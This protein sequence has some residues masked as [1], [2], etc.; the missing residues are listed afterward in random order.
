MKGFRKDKPYKL[1]K[2]YVTE[3]ILREDLGPALLGSNSRGEDVFQWNGRIYA[4]EADLDR[5][6]QEA[7]VRDSALTRNKKIERAKARVASNEAI[8]DKSPREPIP[9]DVKTAVWQ[10]DGGRCQ[11]CGSNVDLE[12]DHII[13]L[14]MGGSNTVRNLQLLC[15]TCNR[16]KGPNLV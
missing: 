16:E 4:V 12:F 5:M 14:A 2:N 15:A 6:S 8:A 10:R 11:R 9:E 3:V 1:I 7:L 13:P